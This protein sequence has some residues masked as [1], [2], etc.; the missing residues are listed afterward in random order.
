MGLAGLTLSLSLSLSRHRHRLGHRRG[1]PNWSSTNCLIKTGGGLNAAAPRR[2]HDGPA[3]ATG[4]RYRAAMRPA[5]QG[6]CCLQPA[7]ARNSKHHPRGLQLALAWPAPRSIQ[8]HPR[9]LQQ[10]TRRRRSPWPWC[11]WGRPRGFPSAKPPCLC[12]THRWYFPNCAWCLSIR[13]RRAASAP[14]LPLASSTAVHCAVLPVA[15]I[16]S[17][18]ATQ[19]N[20]KI[21]QRWNEAPSMG[22]PRLVACGQSWQGG[23][24]R[25]MRGG[26]WWCVDDGGGGGWTM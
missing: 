11:G 14:A 19:S 6:P 22:M 24:W 21:L 20:G 13:R 18:T 2:H 1:N 12:R 3:P 25:R 8:E 9:G 26:G 4:R 7:R 15:L 5:P 16:Y 17:S 10:Q 23:G